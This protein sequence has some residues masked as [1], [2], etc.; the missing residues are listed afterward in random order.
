[1]GESRWRVHGSTLLADSAG[2]SGRMRSN[3]RH[4]PLTPPSLFFLSFFFC[5]LSLAIAPSKLSTHSH[6]RAAILHIFLLSLISMRCHRQI[7]PG[8]TAAATR[9]AAISPAISCFPLS[10]SRLR[11]V[12][13][14]SPAAS[15]VLPHYTHSYTCPLDSAPTHH[16]LPLVRL[17]SS[18]PLFCREVT[19]CNKSQIHLPP[20]F[21]IC[22]SRLGPPV[23]FLSWATGGRTIKEEN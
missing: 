16:P 3:T 20:F 21:F 14:V 22:L 1:M 8:G 10:L 9:L 6:A 17:V 5:S 13:S 7:A 15:P 2:A 12:P 18:P 11:A 19:S 4:Y 23:Q